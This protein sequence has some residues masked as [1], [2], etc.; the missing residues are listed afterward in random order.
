MAYDAA[1]QMLSLTRYSDL[2]GTQLVADSSYEYD[3]FGRLI[4]LTDAQGDIT[5]A[6]YNWVYDE[7]N[8]ITSFTSPDGTANYSYDDTSQVIGAD[9]DYQ[10]NESYS[11]IIMVIALMRVM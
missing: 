4:N 2:A 9:Y 6:A 10:E 7:A 1:S 3:D 11:M 5:L 8:R